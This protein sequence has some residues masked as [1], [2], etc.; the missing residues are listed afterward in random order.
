MRIEKLNSDKVK[1]MLTTADLLTLDVDVSRLS[2]NS[3]ELHTFL[4][5]IMETIH[6][7]TGF[8]PYNGQVVVEATPLKDGISI[9]V[10]R[11]NAVSKR[12]TRAEFN[13][14]TSVTA[15]IKKHM[16]LAMFYFDKFED[17]CAALTEIS[18]EALRDGSLYKVDNSFCFTLRDIH[19]HKKSTHTMTE[20]S[21]DRKRFPA[22]ITYIQEHGKLVAEG[23]ELI[24]LRKNIRNLI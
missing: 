12:I 4:F 11:I 2:P 5:H 17:L 10:S 24:D 16:N 9:I 23:N 20:F 7:E 15:H 1:V 19:K 21:A 3:K 22:H 13:N 18:N 8:D 14:A 6:K